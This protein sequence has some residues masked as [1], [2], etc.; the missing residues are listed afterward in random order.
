[1]E[2]D[3]IMKKNKSFK[4]KMSDVIDGVLLILLAV[5]PFTIYFII[6]PNLPNDQNYDYYNVTILEM[7]NTYAVV[8][9]D[10]EQNVVENRITV[11]KDKEGTYLS[12]K[13]PEFSVGSHAVLIKR[14]TNSG[15]TVYT[16]LTDEELSNYLEKTE[17]VNN[18][19]K[20]IK[21]KRLVEITGWIYS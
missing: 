14:H 7:T 2:E 15:K 3:Y 17:G 9:P 10:G 12:I 20:V 19:G 1:M 4:E 21:R 13:N 6:N 11:E 5:Y 18:D 16:L 8:I